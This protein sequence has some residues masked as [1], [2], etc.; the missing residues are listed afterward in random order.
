MSVRIDSNRVY[1]VVGP[2]GKAG[3]GR[4][5]VWCEVRFSDAEIARRSGRIGRRGAL[6]HSL[7]PIGPDAA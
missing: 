3:F 1:G 6:F 5:G 7:S 2:G 4:G